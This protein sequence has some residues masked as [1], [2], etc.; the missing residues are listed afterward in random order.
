MKLSTFSFSFFLCIIFLASCGSKSEAPNENID[1]ELNEIVESREYK[2]NG[3]N[4]IRAVSD[5]I[6]SG[7]GYLVI[8]SVS[9]DES[10]PR[11]PND[12]FGTY[13]DNRATVKVVRTNTQSAEQDL[14]NT[15]SSVPSSQF[16]KSSFIDYLDETLRTYAVLDALTFVGAEANRFTVEASISVPHSDEQALITITIGLDGSVS[17]QR[18]TVDNDAFP[19]ED[20]ED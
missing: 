6:N 1:E 12:N 9:P 7:H 20:I 18:S 2:E 8:L 17:M 13:C 16:F 15:Q 3:L 4:K 10:Q 14:T 19:E 11:V 5:T